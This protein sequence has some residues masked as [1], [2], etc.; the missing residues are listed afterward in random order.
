ML[1]IR[2][3]VETASMIV[4]LGGDSGE[5]VF[6]AAELYA[7]G[8]APKVLVTGNGDCQRSRRRLIL[9][10][11][12]EDAITTECESGNTA[13]NAK[14][15]IPLLRANKATKA[16]IVTNW[17]HSARAVRCFE[18]YAPDIQFISVPA[19]NGDGEPSANAAEAVVIMQEYAK[20]AYYAF[21]YGIF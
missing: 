3:Q 17:W 13:E 15:S 21:A 14:F 1:M 4:V 2:D 5:R 20:R 16:L 18:Y 19:S 6:H 7:R 12:P 8:L 11:V 9:A 10:G